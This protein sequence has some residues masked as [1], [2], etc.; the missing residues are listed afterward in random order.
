MR[1]RILFLAGLAVLPIW[2]VWAAALTVP[3]PVMVPVATGSVLATWTITAEG[4]Q[5]HATPVVFLHGGPGL[6]TEARRFEEGAVLR[7]AGFDTI[8]FDQAGGGRSGL[9]KAGDYSLERAI[10]DLEALRIAL[11]QEQMVLWGNSYGATL[12]AL[13]ADRYPARVAGVLLTSPGMFPGFAGKRD[14]G[15]SD[16]DKVVYDKAVMAAINRIDRDGAAA[17]AVLPQPEA[18]RLFDALVAAELIN[19]MVCKGSAVRPTALPGGGNLFAQRLIDRDLKA[20]KFTPA[21]V[22]TVPALIVR[23]SCDY[24][25]AASA[26]RFRS[27]LGGAIVEVAD[28]GHGLLENRAAVVAAMDGF[29]RGALAGVK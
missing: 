23:G 13:Y 4:A 20:L 2:S 28:S 14:Y 7:A 29:A 12:L 3:E 22:S 16:R 17:E 24:V 27:L 19:G 21:N 11:R 15:R 6:Y 26:E 5:R 8:Y 10:A 9:L 25:P 18:G 1:L